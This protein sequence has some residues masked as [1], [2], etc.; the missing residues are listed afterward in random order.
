MERV[1]VEQITTNSPAPT[2]TRYNGVHRPFHCLCVDTS[3]RVR[4]CETPSRALTALADAAMP[5]DSLIGLPVAPSTYHFSKSLS[6]VQHVQFRSRNHLAPVNR[7]PLEA[8]AAALPPPTS[9]VSSS[10]LTAAPLVV[11][12]YVQDGGVR[13]FA[14]RRTYR[15]HG[16]CAAASVNFIPSRCGAGSCW[17]RRRTEEKKYFFVIT[18]TAIRRCFVSCAP[19]I[20][21]FCQNLTCSA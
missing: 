5:L 20:I 3:R 2:T 18:V 11:A 13:C 10:S 12:H 7:L 17:T 19:L 21:C 14:E 9:A 6:R 16:R 1:T 15:W 8:P 4:T